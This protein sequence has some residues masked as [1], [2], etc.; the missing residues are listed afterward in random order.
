MIGKSSEYGGSGIKVTPID[1][2]QDRLISGTSM[3]FLVCRP[4][5]NTACSLRTVTRTWK[6]RREGVMLKG[7]MGPSFYLF[8]RYQM[9]L[10]KG[11]DS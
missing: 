10:Q 4:L 5:T 3:G 6:W 2:Q 11:D 9:R 1:S 7:M 8:V